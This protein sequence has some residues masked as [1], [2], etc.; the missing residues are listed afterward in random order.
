MTSSEG[1]RT[2]LYRACPKVG[3]QLNEYRVRQCRIQ[4]E[5]VATVDLT[6]PLKA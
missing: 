2:E 1:L 6:E 4:D 3:Y 5:L